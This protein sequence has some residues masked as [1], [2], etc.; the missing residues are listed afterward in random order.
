MATQPNAIGAIAKARNVSEMPIDMCA[1]LINVANGSWA[2]DYGCW[3]WHDGNY[4]T[5]TKW[6]NNVPDGTYVVRV[7]FWMNGAC[8]NE[9]SSSCWGYGYYGGAESPRI[10]VG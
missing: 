3:G 10:T 7:G 1:Q 5:Y 4:D 6:D 8:T 2:Y 9:N